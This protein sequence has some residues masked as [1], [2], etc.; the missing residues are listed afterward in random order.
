M[1]V[2]T[3]DCHLE[4]IEQAQFKHGVRNMTLYSLGVVLLAIGEM[5]PRRC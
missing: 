4:L 3:E 2:E 5:D 1:D